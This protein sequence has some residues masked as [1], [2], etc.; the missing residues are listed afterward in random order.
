MQNIGHC[1]HANVQYTFQRKEQRRALCMCVQ[2]KKESFE[3]VD[4][5][6]RNI[7]NVSGWTSSVITSAL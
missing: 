3:Q 6:Q 7:F 5:E 2:I 4:T 1:K